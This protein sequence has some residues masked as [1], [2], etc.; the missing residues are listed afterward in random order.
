MITLSDNK[1]RTIEISYNSD[2][3]TET[4]EYCK[5]S[6][7]INPPNITCNNVQDAQYIQQQIDNFVCN[8]IRDMMK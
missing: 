5:L 6:Y 3:I 1:G 4:G 7:K 2:I 8:L